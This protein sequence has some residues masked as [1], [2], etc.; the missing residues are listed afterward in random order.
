MLGFIS[1]IHILLIIIYK[2]NYFVC[3]IDNIAFVGF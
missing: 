2:Y 3:F 1:F